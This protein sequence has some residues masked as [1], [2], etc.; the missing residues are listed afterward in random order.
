MNE[1]ATN[2]IRRRFLS[3][4]MM[5]NYLGAGI[6]QFTMLIGDPAQFQLFVIASMVYL[7]AL[8]PILLTRSNA[9]KPLSPQ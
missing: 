1:R 7:F 2:Q 4:Y 9:P 3:L 8:V 6:G 5:T